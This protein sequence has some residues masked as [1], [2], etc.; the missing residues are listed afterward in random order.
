MHP[1]AVQRMYNV[2]WC[3]LRLIVVHQM[4]GKEASGMGSGTRQPLRQCKSQREMVAIHTL[5]KMHDSHSKS[6][7]KLLVQMMQQ[8]QEGFGV[9]SRG[10]LR[11]QA[12]QILCAVRVT[13]ARSG[14]MLTGS[15]LLR[16][17]EL[18]AAVGSLPQARLQR[19]LQKQEKC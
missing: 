5:V 18:R 2:E 8:L 4:L 19:R 3:L 7:Q 12:R 14:G 17:E 11:L 6:R 13:T 16:P 15:L 9:Q 10:L 1:K